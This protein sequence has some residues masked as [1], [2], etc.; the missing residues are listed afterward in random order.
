MENKTRLSEEIKDI[1]LNRRKKVLLSVYQVTIILFVLII[2][3]N[4]FYNNYSNFLVGLTSLFAI[5]FSFLYFYRRKKYDIASHVVLFVIGYSIVFSIIKSSFGDYTPVYIISFT[6]FT[7]FLFSWKKSIVLNLLFF[8]VLLFLTILFF[9][10]LIDDFLLK[11]QIA[12]INFLIIYF[13]IFIF[14][15]FYEVTRIEA[16]K[17]LMKSSYK[18]DLLYKEVHHRVKN[19]LNIIS[20]MLSMQAQK[21]SKEVQEIIKISKTRIEAI[22]IVHSML[23]VSKSV[24]KVHLKSFL[25]Q[26]SVN[27]KTISDTSVQISIDTKEI[28]LPLNTIIPIGLIA[29]ELLVNSFKYAFNNTAYPKIT[30]TIEALYDN[31]MLTY[32]DNGVG[33][34]PASEKNIGLKIVDLNVRQL[35]GTIETSSKKGLEYKITFKKGINV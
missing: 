15:Y 26:L 7:F 23:Y 11:N 21:E 8:L 24:E 16:Y 5:T 20:S 3:K 14:T 22:A 35:K 2:L 17:L 1:I 34:K 10:N 18:K 27:L 31:Y 19:N 13:T 32:H 30:I 9:N 4:L 6:V 33:L 25:E 29:N 12:L 28:E